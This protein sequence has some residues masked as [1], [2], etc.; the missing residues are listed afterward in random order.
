MLRT[1]TDTLASRAACAK[2]RPAPSP[3]PILL[4]RPARG[5]V[6]PQ[7]AVARCIDPEHL[8]EKARAEIACARDITAMKNAMNGA[9]KRSAARRNRVWRAVHIVDREV[10]AV[11]KDSSY[12]QHLK[13]HQCRQPD[14][15][16]IRSLRGLS[17]SIGGI[18]HGH[19]AAPT[20]GPRV[21]KKGV[22][23]GKI[24]REDTRL[25]RGAGLRRAVGLSD[26]CPPTAGRETS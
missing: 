1:V 21:D 26:T 7:P 25:P 13:R 9:V 12:Y 16:V 14:A 3:M 10:P 18:R 23:G 5:F 2:S 22:A 8:V 4:H 11:S 15:F 17:A 20:A 24:H 19:W 6:S